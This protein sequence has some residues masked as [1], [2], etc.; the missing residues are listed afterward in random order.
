MLREL[1]QA[2]ELTVPIQEID[3]WSENYCF[4][5]YD[6][7][8][9]LGLWLHMGRWSKQPDLWREQ[10]KIYLPD[11]TLL[12]WKAI[13]G[14]GESDGPSS[15]TL[16]FACPGPGQWV[17]S[18][19]G[20]CRRVDLDR[21]KAGPLPDGPWSRLTAEFRFD[22]VQPVWDLDADADHQIW[23]TSHYEQPGRV[24]GSIVVDGET[25]TLD[26][27]SAY[28]DHSRGPR[29][30]KGMRR[31]V[32]IHGQTDGNE[33]FGLFY[34]EVMGQPG[35]SRAF[36]TPGDGTIEEVEV[37]GPPYSD[38]VDEL[39]GDFGFGL[40]FSSGREISV[41]A[42]PVNSVLSSFVFPYEKLH[43]LSP[44]ASHVSCHQTT[45]FMIDGVPAAGM[46]ER[47]FVRPA[48]LIEP[49]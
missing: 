38:E 33:A 24:N 39:F 47:S 44:T 17:L 3:F 36:W 25:F 48:G 35:L 23:C 29:N 15:A 41:S 42:T 16:R 46:T 14:R 5:A 2:D 7:E 1:T 6:A 8:N 4:D 45:R 10:T 49:S 26:N 31:H 13:G 12:L 9:E 21:L 22:S 34:M 11:G 20:A 30:M 27:A 32:W 40:G 18:F 43:G 28:R 37:L 19:D